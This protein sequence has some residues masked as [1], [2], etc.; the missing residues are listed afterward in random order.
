MEKYFVILILIVISYSLYNCWVDNKIEKILKTKEGFADTL[1]KSDSDLLQSITTLGQIADKLQGPN[2]L[3]VPGKMNCISGVNVTGILAV[4]NRN[5]IAELDSLRTDMNNITNGLRNDMNNITGGLRN[6]TNGLRTDVNVLKQPKTCRA[7][8]SAWT[9]G[10]KRGLEY[11]DRQRPTCGN[12][13]TISG[14]GV[15]TNGNYIRY[16]YTCCK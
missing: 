16:N 7:V 1:T 2:G 11:L 10:H 9:D 14:F 12:N 4:N 8:E 3:T 15:Q 13:E 5:I 6:D